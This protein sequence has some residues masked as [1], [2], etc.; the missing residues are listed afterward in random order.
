MR[1]EA[2]SKDKLLREVSQMG[3]DIHVVLEKKFGGK[4]IGVREVN[5]FH[6]YVHDENT[7]TWKSTPIW[8][9]A[10]MRNYDLFTRLANVRGE[11]GPAPKGL[12]E[13][14]SELAAALFADD[15]D[16]HSHSWCSLKDYLE[17][18]VASEYEPAKVF[19]KDKQPQLTHPAGYYFGMYEPEE[20]EEYRVVFC[21]DN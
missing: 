14:V 19:L 18:L 17:A 7:D 21:F 3:C 13:D 6:N 20:D 12:P 15:D 16:Y 2:P 4:W 8:C 9:R 1:A 5:H 10:R 11:G